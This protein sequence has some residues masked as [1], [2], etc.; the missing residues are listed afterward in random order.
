MSPETIVPS[1]AAERFDRFCLVR[2]FGDAFEFL[3]DK[4]FNATAV[5]A[6]IDPATGKRR[7]DGLKRNQFGGTLGGPIVRD[8]LFFF[9]GYQGISQG[10]VSPARMAVT[11]C[12]MISS[13]S[14]SS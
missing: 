13:S 4:R 5:F 3:R 6:G 1:F 7:D 9:G 12:A 14:D 8:R 11:P 10:A 2:L